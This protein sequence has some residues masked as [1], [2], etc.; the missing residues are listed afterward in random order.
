MVVSQNFDSLA[1]YLVVIF[2]VTMFSTSV[3]ESSE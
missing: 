2:A 3:S 1:P